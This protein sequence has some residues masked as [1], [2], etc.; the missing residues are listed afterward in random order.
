MFSSPNICIF[1]K[2]LNPFTASYLQALEIHKE[3]VARREIGA[4][5]SS[6]NITRTQKVVQPSQRERPQKYMRHRIDFNS[7]DHI[8]HGVRTSSN[9]LPRKF[10]S[11]QAEVR[12]HKCTVQCTIL[13][14]ECTCTCSLVLYHSVE[15]NTNI[16]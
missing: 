4:L 8:G 3:K 15:Y 12:S 9:E 13:A 5:A 11:T 6:K 2:L 10:T 16:I 14:L 1:C 7:L